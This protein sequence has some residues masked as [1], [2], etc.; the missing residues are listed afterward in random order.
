MNTHDALELIRESVTR[1]G[2]AWADLGAGDGMFTR[3]LIGLLGPTGRVYAVDR[4]ARAIAELERWATAEGARVVP[5]VAD[6][7]RPDL[8]G[9]EGSMLDGMLFA[10]SLHFVR[11][12][13]IVLARLAAWLKPGGRVVWV[14]YDRASASRWVPYPIPA[15]RLPAL[16]AAAGLSTPVITGTRP[17]AFGGNLYAA[18]ARR[19]A[20]GT[21]STSGDRH[22]WRGRPHDEPGVARSRS[23]GRASRS[24]RASVVRPADRGGPTPPQR[25]PPSDRSAI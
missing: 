18:E 12:A 15:A 2:G 22:R 24:P 16:A 21:R 13:E 3:A 5:V 25:T 14:E 23:R 19:P 7:T 9:F 8:P 11:D 6:F 17:S 4:D 20:G 1:P 10:N